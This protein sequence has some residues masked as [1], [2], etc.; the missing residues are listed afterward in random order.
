MTAY[1]ARSFARSLAMGLL[2][3]ALAAVVMI[4]TDTDAGASGSRLARLGALAPVF[5]ALGSSLAI[6][7][8]RS[9]GELLALESI[10]VPRW[11]QMAG[12]L[13]AAMLIGF[14]GAIAVGSRAS[15]LGALFPRIERSDWVQLAD[16]SWSSVA[17]G[18]KIGPA[19]LELLAGGGAAASM[20][21]PRSAGAAVMLCLA[22]ATIAL[23]LWLQL[24][25][26]QLERL[27]VGGCTALGQIALFHWVGAGQ[28]SA[29]ALVAGPALLLVHWLIRK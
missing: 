12:A 17:A 5:G 10:G 24:R 9:K 29:W 19:G 14:A 16:G 18:A 6:A 27:G 2:L 1:D 23:P 20:L 4:A 3:L 11:R 7:Q 8:A 15:N 28:L 21:D 26:R 22:A 25:A 13:A